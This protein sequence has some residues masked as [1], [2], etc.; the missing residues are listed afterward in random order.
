MSDEEEELTDDEGWTNVCIVFGTAMTAVET[1]RYF[2][3]DACKLLHQYLQTKTVKTWRQNVLE[4]NDDWI[5][6]FRKFERG[7]FWNMYGLYRV[8]GVNNKAIH[9]KD[10]DRDVCVV[11][12]IVGGFNLP[13]HHARYR[14]TKKSQYEPF[15]YID[16]CE[17][18]KEK[19][20]SDPKL[21]MWLSDHAKELD[22]Y[23]VDTDKWR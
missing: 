6:L 8:H 10:E 17:R 2:V 18:I 20:R 16:G 14:I 5:E 3:D 9:L 13:V 22:E 4:G 21:N 12:K 23:L 15:S 1:V 19:V 11:G 7:D